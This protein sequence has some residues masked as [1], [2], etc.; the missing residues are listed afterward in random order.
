MKLERIHVGPNELIE[1]LRELTARAE[2][3]ERECTALRLIL[4]DGTFQDVAFGGTEE[5]QQAALRE[6]RKADLH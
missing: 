3:G 2:A 5:E 4:K 6:L 1:K